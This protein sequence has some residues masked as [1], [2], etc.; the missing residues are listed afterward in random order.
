MEINNWN[1]TSLALLVFLLTSSCNQVDG[2]YELERAHHTKIKSFEVDEYS[3]FI[4]FGINSAYLATYDLV[5]EKLIV[6]DKSNENT[7]T[8][9][10][11]SGSGPNEVDALS[12]I[13][14]DDNHVVHLVDRG[15]S[16]II[17]YDIIRNEKSEFISE[18]LAR[19][20]MR[21][22][23][24]ND[25][26]IL[27][28]LNAHDYLF[29]SYKPKSDKAEVIA[30]GEVDLED[31][32]PLPP[33]KDGYI[34]VS[35]HT[36]GY[37]LRYEPRIFWFDLQEKEYL[38]NQLFEDYGDIGYEVPDEDAGVVLPPDEVPIANWGIMQKP[39][40]DNTFLLS[41]EGR[42]ESDIRYKRN[43]LYVMDPEQGQIE[44]GYAISEEPDNIYRYL[45]SFK[46]VYYVDEDWN[47][48]RIDF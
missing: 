9:D 43:H 25:E 38:G 23:I 17:A 33:F 5:N 4:D 48:Y 10:I 42:S 16:K 27:L 29:T 3:S 8:I 37:L 41:I 47:L 28:D 11:R 26:L 39:Q 24:Y 30:E 35:D 19:V 18:D 7:Q 1:R 2:D 14:I 20:F 31:H 12:A 21:G 13:M 40:S 46:N 44:K 45:T 36:L 22:E 6:F 32:F 34:A 15:N